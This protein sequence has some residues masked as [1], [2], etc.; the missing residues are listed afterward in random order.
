MICPRCGAQNSD[1]ARFCSN[2][3][4]P[5]AA[6]VAATSGVAAANTTRDPNTAFVLELLLGLF[7]F[8]GI[9]WVY[10]GK[11]T[12]GIVMLVSWWLIVGVGLGG[13]VLTGFIGCCLWLPVHFVVPLVSAMLIRNEIEQNPWG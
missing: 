12:L 3:G 2:C 11:T 1:G 8:L 7:G 5:L 10:A 6:Q 13:S 9:G 4:Q